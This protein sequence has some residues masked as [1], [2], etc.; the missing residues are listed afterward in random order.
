[1]N[2][3]IG[4]VGSKGSGKDTVADLSIKKFNA[5]KKVSLA[6]P[7]KA[8]MKELFNFSLHSLYDPKG[9]DAKLKDDIIL[10]HKLLRLLVH[11]VSDM[12]NEYY[13]SNI[14]NP[15]SIPLS[16][17]ERKKFTTNNTYRD[18]VRYVAT[19]IIRS[20]CPTWHIEMALK[21]MPKNG[22]VFITD[23]RF[24]NEIE[25]LSKKDNFYLVY[26]KNDKAED[27][28]KDTHSSESL[29]RKVKEEKIKVFGMID[30][31]GDFKNLEKECGNLFKLIQKNALKI[32]KK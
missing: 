30:N 14:I 6:S 19:E 5:K 11:K 22:V 15:Y 1:M 18:V 2:V 10:S 24:D 32:K 21:K 20:F 9:K 31:N 23:I 8:L 16:N 25:F 12:Y 28:N 4:L 17:W 27:K 13:D 3:I 29:F 7:L 26:I